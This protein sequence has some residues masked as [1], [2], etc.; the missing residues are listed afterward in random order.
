MNNEAWKRIPLWIM[1]LL[2]TGYI[3]VTHADYEYMVLENK[4]MKMHFIEDVVGYNYCD[5]D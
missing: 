5:K 1:I 3:F 2:L 4:L